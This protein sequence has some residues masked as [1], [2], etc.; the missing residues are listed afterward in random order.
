[1]T[2]ETDASN[3]K[4]LTFIESHCEV[5]DRQFIDGRVTIQATI[6]KKTLA[7]LSR[8]DQVEVKSV[9]TVESN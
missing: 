7:D 8:N 9:G 3:G 5:K 1:M 6:G 4:L 2:L